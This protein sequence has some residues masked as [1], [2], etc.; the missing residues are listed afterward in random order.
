MGGHLV[1][2]EFGRLIEQ[3]LRLDRQLPGTMIEHRERHVHLA[4]GEHPN[5]PDGREDNTHFNELG[6]RRMAE[7]V[8]ADIRVLK[9][10]LVAHLRQGAVKKAVDP[11][12]R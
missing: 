6:A 2:G 4:P 3:L 1:G 7:L 9:L 10:D 12:A 5:Y 11:Q 8:L